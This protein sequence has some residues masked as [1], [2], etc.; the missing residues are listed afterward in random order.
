[1]DKYIEKQEGTNKMGVRDQEGLTYISQINLWYDEA[2]NVYL[3]EFGEEAAPR[4]FKRRKADRDDGDNKK[5]FSLDAITLSGTQIVQLIILITAAVTQYNVISNRI[6]E[7]EHKISTVQ[8]TAEQ[9]NQV[10]KDLQKQVNTLE[11]QLVITNETLNNLQ[12]RLV[13]KK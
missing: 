5:H 12:Y 3:D 8:T 2:N 13:S 9:Y 6:L 4:V 11:S 7:L 10:T 1:V